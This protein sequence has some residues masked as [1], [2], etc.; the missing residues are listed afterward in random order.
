MNAMKQ[1]RIE[2]LTFNFGSGKEQAKL[3][4]GMRLIK[5]ITGIEPVKTH[6]QKR[7]PSWGLR[8]GLP[9]GCKLTLRKDTKPLLARLLKAVKNRLN[10]KNFDNNGTVSI[11]IP[12]YIEI[13]DVE[14]DPKIGIIGFEVM[15][16]LTRPGFRVKKRRLMP[17][18]ISKGHK[19]TREEAIDFMKKEFN[20][21]VQK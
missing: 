5:H 13:P 19:I 9:V 14:Y 2:K 3:E 7:I 10:E 6:T 1:I 16:T 17:A 20:V 12:E 18:K 15:V 4:K 8:P 21:E 11:G